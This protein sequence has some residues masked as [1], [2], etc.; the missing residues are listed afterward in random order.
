MNE[1]LTR[2]RSSDLLT[3]EHLSFLVIRFIEIDRRPPLL[4]YCAKHWHHHVHNCPY[5]EAVSRAV[6]AFLTGTEV[7]K[8]VTQY[9]AT[10]LSSVRSA[11]PLSDTVEGTGQWLLEHEKFVKWERGHGM[12]RVLYCP[13]DG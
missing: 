12:T 2:L 4:L 3:H 5:N 8:L 9:A 13:G 1:Y 6:L 11:R 7:L 10:W